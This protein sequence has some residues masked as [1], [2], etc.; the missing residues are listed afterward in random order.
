MNDKETAMCC[1]TALGSLMT[2]AYIAYVTVTHGDGAV[3]AS[4]CTAIGAIIGY[5]VKLGTSKTP[6]KKDDSEE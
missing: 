5:V 2:A 4:F 3:L 6:E 1:C